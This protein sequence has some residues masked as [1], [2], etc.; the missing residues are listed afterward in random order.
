MI[1]KIKEH[2][3]GDNKPVINTWAKIFLILGINKEI[4]CSDKF[5]IKIWEKYRELQKKLAM[6]Q[7]KPYLKWP[8]KTFLEILNLPNH[9]PQNTRPGIWVKLLSGLIESKISPINKPAIKPSIDPWI[10]D[11]GNNQNKGQ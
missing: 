10:I 2:N 1:L 6:E 11:Q 3:N 7:I 8:T 4:L 9:I 5:L